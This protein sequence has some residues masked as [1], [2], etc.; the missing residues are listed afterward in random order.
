MSNLKLV[1]CSN[2]AC[3]A[4]VFIPGD[5]PPLATEPCKKCGYPIMMP[6]QLRQ[7]ELQSKIAS[8]GHGKVYR[9]FDTVLSRYVAVKLMRKELESDPVAL[10]SFYR[11]ARACASFNHTNIIHIYSYDELDG[12]RYLVMELADAGSLDSLI[13]R[14]QRVGEYEVLQIGIKIASALN[15]VLR[16]N[17]LHR[18]I[19]PGN[20]LFN[21]ENEPKL[22]DFGLARNVDAEP[23]STTVTEGTPYYVAPEKIKREKETPLSDMYSLGCTLY[24]ALTGHVPFE[25][26]SVEELVAAHVH[27]APT[28]PNRVSPEVTQAT[29][30]AIMKAME[31]NPA[32]RFLSY[33]EFQMAFEAARTYFL[34]QS[35][36]AQPKKPKSTTSWWKKKTT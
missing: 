5:L 15:M 31:K 4:K 19:K 3:Q 8:G 9:A 10:E 29:S 35:Q 2:P 30:D 26:P 21:T 22:V 24:H 7:F 27:T 25:A 12:Q 28:P 13:E 18:D 32:D 1:T 20:I 17:L 6:M 14:Q 36:Q 23:E 16:H 34:L 11:E 33:D